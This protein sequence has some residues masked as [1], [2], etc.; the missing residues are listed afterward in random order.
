M[1]LPRIWPTA[2]V[3]VGCAWNSTMAQ[4]KTAVEVGVL[5]CSFSQSG[6]VETGRA[7]VEVQVRDILCSFK[8]SSGAEETYTGKLLGVS[9]SA[10]HKGTLLWLVKTPSAATPLAPGLLQQSYAA[11]AKAPVD[12]IPAMIG[13][14]N[15]DIVLESMVDQSEGGSGAPEKSPAGDLAIFGLELQL[16]STA[17]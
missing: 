17:G 2:L 11:D 9:L 16:K 13:E 4:Q 14:A 5:A 15:S 3:V 8:L 12:Q 10:E 1:N 7:G 6:Q